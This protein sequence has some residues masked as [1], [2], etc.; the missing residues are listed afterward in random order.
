[1]LDGIPE[2]N[3]IHGHLARVIVVLFQGF[4]QLCL[5]LGK[6]NQVLIGLI[7]IHEIT[8]NRRDLL[9][10]NVVKGL[11]KDLPQILRNN[12]NERF[13]ILFINE[14]VRENSKA[15][16]NPQANERGLR[17]HP[18]LIAL[19]Q[20]LE[21]LGN[22]PQ[23][24]Q[25]MDFGW[26]RQ[27]L[28]NN[29]LV[30]LNRRFGHHVT[31][32]LELVFELG[33]LLVYHRSKDSVDLGLARERHIDKVKARLQSLADHGTTPTWGT[34]GSHQEHVLNV[35]GCLLLSVIPEAPIDPQPDQLEWWLRSIE[36]LSRHIEVVN[37]CDHPLAA[38]RDIDPLGAL[39]NSRLNDLLDHHGRS[40]GRDVYDQAAVI[41]GIHFAY[42][43]LRDGRFACAHRAAQQHR[44]L[45]FNEAR[46]Q[47]VVSDS[48]DSWDCYLVKRDG[49][50]VFPA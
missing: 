3:Y 33:Q 43:G 5:E 39:L 48:V 19:Q 11:V 2:Q 25:V 45:G 36:V 18:L 27:E 47:V 46:D 24:K 4:F 6:I 13:A 16:V 49:G 34:H 15:L 32:L 35:L 17:C 44:I 37:E 38:D 29:C 21:H 28:G 30:H 42:D 41:H 14:T 26:R 22:I 20:A 1:M 31:K 12:A 8:K 50:V 7:V 9:L 23:I 10:A 40:L